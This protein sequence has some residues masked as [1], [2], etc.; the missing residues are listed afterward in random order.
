MCLNCQ[1]VASRNDTDC[2]DITL[3]DLPRLERIAVAR[4]SGGTGMLIGL[5]KPAVEPKELLTP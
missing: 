2:L 3:C 4:A 1:V 5:W